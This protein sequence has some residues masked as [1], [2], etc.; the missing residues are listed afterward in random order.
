MTLCPLCKENEL[1]E[2]ET[3]CQKCWEAAKGAIERKRESEEKIILKL[4][5][6]AKQDLFEIMA[7][8]CRNCE[9]GKDSI[10]VPDHVCENC[11]WKE[12]E[13][14]IRAFLE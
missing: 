10:S 12:K 14:L 5:G 2:W 4:K 1:K 8:I 7:L 13:K 6:K 9:K 11:V 3:L